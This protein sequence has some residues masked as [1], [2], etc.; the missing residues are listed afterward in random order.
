MR[1]R[2]RLTS[3][4]P[5]DVFQL[6]A[7]FLGQRDRTVAQVEEF[8]TSR[9]VSSLQVKR[10]IRRLSELRY[11]D[12]VAYAKR[13]VEKRLSSRPMGRERLKV[14]LQAKGIADSM[15]DRAVGDVF[16]AISEEA[17]AQRVVRNAQRHGRRLTPPHIARLLQQ[18]GFAQET[19]D[20]IMRQYGLH[21]DRAHE[22]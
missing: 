18:R 7:R 3:S 10:A 4:G 9:G 16:E 15:A 19:I 2:S 20:H 17:L 1:A 6:A 22:E 12:D 13:Y 5:D 11:L 8:L 21:E 14:E